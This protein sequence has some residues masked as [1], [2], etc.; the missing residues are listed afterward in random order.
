MFSTCYFRKISRFARNDK[1]LGLFTISSYICALVF[2]VLFLFRAFEL[3]CF[4]DCFFMC[5]LL[6]HGIIS[7]TASRTM[8][9]DTPLR[10]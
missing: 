7:L 8:S 3:S 10:H 4:R 1:L 2:F 9:T 5:L 6:S